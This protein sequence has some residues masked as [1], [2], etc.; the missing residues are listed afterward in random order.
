M[1]DDKSSAQMILEQPDKSLQTFRKQTKMLTAVLQELRGVD[2]D[3]T[4]QVATTL[5]VIASNPGIT[6]GEISQSVGIGRAAVSRHA[7]VLGPFN[8]HLQCGFNLVSQTVDWI[9]RRRKPMYL[10][11]FGRALIAKLAHV[12]VAK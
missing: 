6:Q 2:P 11:D 10:T 7:A 8:P 5:M 9:D 4:V 12:A 3:M 1:T